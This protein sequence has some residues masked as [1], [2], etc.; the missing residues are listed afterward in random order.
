MAT[1]HKRY[2]KPVE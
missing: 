2:K 1:Q